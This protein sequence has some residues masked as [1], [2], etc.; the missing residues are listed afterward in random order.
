VRGHVLLLVLF[1]GCAT[2]PASPLESALTSLRQRPR[3]LFGDDR[4]PAD[5]APAAE[6]PA[7]R[8]ANACVADLRSCVARC[9]A[10]DGASCY[11]AALR[12]Q[13]LQSDEPASEALFLQ[14]CRLGI[15]SGCTNRAAGI[16]K[17]NAPDEAAIR[18]AARTFELTCHAGDPWGCTMLGFHLMN[19]RGIGKDLD[20]AHQVLKQACVRYGKD[21]PACV[22]A[23]E[24]VEQI[25]AA[26][27]GSQTRGPSGR[28]RG[29]TASR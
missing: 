10:H 17:G 8:K 9:Q 1:A 13:E 18:C 19:G 5:V 12:V 7:A 14:A 6:Q 16:E 22:R 25:E 28:A 24:M 27:A 26:R 21:D 2:V 4:C 29:A 15:M 23:M 11:A 3:W 20:R